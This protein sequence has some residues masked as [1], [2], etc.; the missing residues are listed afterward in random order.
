MPK[1]RWPKRELPT[2]RLNTTTKTNRNRSKG[3]RSLRTSRHARQIEPRGYAGV[4]AAEEQVKAAR[5]AYNAQLAAL[6][7]PPS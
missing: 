6:K 2:I 4:N 1:P 3:R 7:T 5:G